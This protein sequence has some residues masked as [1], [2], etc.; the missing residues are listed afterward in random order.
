M[1]SYY[2]NIIFYISFYEVNN[3]FNLNNN[4]KKKHKLH[5]I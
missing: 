1:D 5:F 4:K 2:M 3:N